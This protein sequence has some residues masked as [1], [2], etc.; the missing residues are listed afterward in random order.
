MKYHDRIVEI[1]QRLHRVQDYSGNRRGSGAGPQGDGA[2]RRPRV[3]RKRSRRRRDVFPGVTQMNNLPCSILLVED[4]P[5]DLDLTVRAFSQQEMVNPIETAEH[6]DVK[7][8][9]ELGAN[10][11]IV[12]PVSLENFL[13]VA[14][15][16]EL[17]WCV[18]NQWPLL[19]P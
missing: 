15:Q 8:A 19:T 17:Y 13:A 18:L 4:N 6:R 3:G 16:I 10:S 5:M 7:T 9:Y 12:K 14:A 1:F 2:A 11:Y